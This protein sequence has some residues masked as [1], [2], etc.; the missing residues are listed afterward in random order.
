MKI[1][2]QDKCK[3]RR[4]DF[5]NSDTPI[6]EFDFLYGD[7]NVLVEMD[8]K[9]IKPILFN[10]ERF[11]KQSQKII[12]KD[13]MKIVRKQCIGI[14]DFK[15]SH[16]GSHLSPFLLT[17][18]YLVDFLPE[19]QA[20]HRLYRLYQSRDSYSKRSEISQSIIFEPT[21]DS[22]FDRIPNTCCIY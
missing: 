19:T 10:Y 20:S 4:N 14:Q 1:K 6:K 18:Q 16:I 17:I 5:R 9:E 22:Q 12:K 15:E 7:F 11:Y 3:S 13:Q 2:A 8:R 21:I